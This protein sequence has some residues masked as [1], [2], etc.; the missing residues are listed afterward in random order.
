MNKGLKM[1][2]YSSQNDILMN[3]AGVL[4]Y[5]NT[6]NWNGLRDWQ[7]TTKVQWFIGNKNYGWVKKFK[8]FTYV[9]VKNSGHYVG[10]DQPRAGNAMINN[11]VNDLW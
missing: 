2:I 6:L 5:L 10:V 3:T 4:N 7:K 9:L 8:N 11:F 1:L